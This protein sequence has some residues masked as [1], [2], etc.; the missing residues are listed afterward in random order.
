MFI[1]NTTILFT[2]HMPYGQ[3]AFQHYYRFYNTE[4]PTGKM[5][6]N[7][8]I[9]ATIPDALRAKDALSIS[10]D[11]VIPHS[12]FDNFDKIVFE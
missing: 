8:I 11:K 5:Y 1:K 9:G 7:T 3:N 12:C 6:F 4:C 2:L 10:I